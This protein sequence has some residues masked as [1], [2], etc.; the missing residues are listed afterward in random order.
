MSHGG[1]IARATKRD[2]RRAMGGA[3]VDIVSELYAF[4]DRGFWGRLRWL[5]TGH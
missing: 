3:A 5:L 4:K 1:P 2:L